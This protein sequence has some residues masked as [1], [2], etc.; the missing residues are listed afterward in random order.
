MF[1][2]NTPRQWAFVFV[3]VLL[4]S[5]LVACG[6]SVFVDGGV[7]LPTPIATYATNTTPPAAA[8]AASLIDQELLKLPGLQSLCEAPAEAQFTCENATT[9]PL[10][11]VAIPA[12]T[13]ARWRLQ[14]E[15]GLAPLTG[16]ET[17]I[18]RLRREGNLT[19]NLYLVERTG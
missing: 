19:P 16:D 12:S 5:L 2:T 3:I 17:L 7:T 10:L 6:R 13:H 18:L 1:R 4:I 8:P 9:Q 14:L 11:K 15:E